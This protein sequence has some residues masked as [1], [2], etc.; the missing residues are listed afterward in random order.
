MPLKEFDFTITVG[1]DLASPKLAKT[2]IFKL[3]WL[4]PCFERIPTY[5]LKKTLLHRTS[6]KECFLQSFHSD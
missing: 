2:G 1:V 5:R 6:M 3:Q 4:K